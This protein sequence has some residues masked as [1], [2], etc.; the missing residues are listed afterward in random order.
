M[1]RKHLL[2]I[3]IGVVMV[4]SAI[5]GC[6]N[7]DS[8]DTTTPADSETSSGVVDEAAVALAPRRHQ[9]G[10]GARDRH[11]TLISSG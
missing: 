9:V 8:S 2:A 3:V 4:M 6:S 1:P 5:T 10:R 11:R 7:D